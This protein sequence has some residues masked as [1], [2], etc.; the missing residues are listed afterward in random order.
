MLLKNEHNLLP[1]NLGKTGT[2]IALIGPLMTCNAT[3]LGQGNAP[4]PPPRKGRLRDP[5][6]NW[7]AAREAL[8]GSYALDS[9]EVAIPLLPDAFAAATPPGG[10]TYTVSQVI[11]NH[12]RCNIS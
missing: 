11:V 9:D 8:I 12:F 2:R 5:T 7:C 10:A 3:E 1:L 6:P 4:P